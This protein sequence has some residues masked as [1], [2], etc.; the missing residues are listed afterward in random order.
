MTDKCHAAL[1]R[2]GCTLRPGF[3][4]GES[5]RPAGAQPHLPAKDIPDPLG[6]RAGRA[7][8][9]RAPD[10]WVF[11]M[12]P[13]EMWRVVIK[14]KS[15]FHNMVY[16]SAIASGATS[17]HAVAAECTGDNV[18]FLPVSHKPETPFR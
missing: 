14:H 7:W 6:R 13:V 15:V 17:R 12:A 8:F 1:S 4:G 3:L 5:V 11:V 16:Q 9:V 18:A 2:S 10:F